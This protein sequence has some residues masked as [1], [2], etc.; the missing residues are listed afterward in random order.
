M[1]V[2]NRENIVI[3]ALD[4]ASPLVLCEVSVGNRLVFTKRSRIASTVADVPPLLLEALNSAS[5]MPMDVGVYCVVTGPGPSWT[6]LRVGATL[7]KTLAFAAGAEVLGVPLLKFI[8]EVFAIGEA[9]VT[10]VTRPKPG[11]ILGASFDAT[12][13]P[14]RELTDTFAGSDE[15]AA[16]HFA[17]APLVLWYSD[18]LAPSWF[19]GTVRS[20]RHAEV[21]HGALASVAY[22]SWLAGGSSNPH[23]LIADYAGGPSDW[24]GRR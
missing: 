17:T 8:A 24:E 22:S 16:I 21:P 2:V 20:V 10:V 12:A 19:A 1:P 15:A 9:A 11:H 13:S 18:E 23:G 5:V 14:V 4:T 6:G 3:V 7:A